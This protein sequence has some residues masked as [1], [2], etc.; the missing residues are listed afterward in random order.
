MKSTASIIG[1]AGTNGSGKDT[2][3]QLLQKHCDY[4]FVSVTDMLRDELRRRDQPVDRKHMRGL[5]SEWREKYGMSVLV[6]RALA[7]FKAQKN[8]YQGVVMSSLRNPG[9][10]DRI[11]EI[12]GIMLWID[13][14]P[15]L[16]YMRVQANAAT[17]NRSGE[18]D[19]T[20]QQF[21]K[22]EKAE[23][24]RT[25]DSSAVSLDMSAVKARSDK[26][27]MNDYRNPEDLWQAV[28]TALNLDDE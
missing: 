17:R 7:L 3:G 8:R 26:I 20:Y 13:A 1:L 22:E 2:V 16:R 15:H 24:N 23:M 10:A 5:S 27:V 11:H 28:R 9:E 25:V 12:G 21:L 4:F 14:N 19:K 18:D 6:D